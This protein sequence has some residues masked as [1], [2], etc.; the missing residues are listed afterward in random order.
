MRPFEH[1]QRMTAM[2]RNSNG[3]F[4]RRDTRLTIKA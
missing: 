4:A 2:R 3:E 1:R